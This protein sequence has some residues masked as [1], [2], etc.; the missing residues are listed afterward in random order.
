MKNENQANNM[1]GFLKRLQGVQT[2]HIYYMSHR[3]CPNNTYILHEMVH[4]GTLDVKIV[5]NFT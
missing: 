3:E 2:L 5:H 1:S 4:I